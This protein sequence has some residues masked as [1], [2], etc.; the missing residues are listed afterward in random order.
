MKRFFCSLCCFLLAL[1]LNAQADRA[2]RIPGELIVSLVDGV[3]T[4]QWFKEHVVNRSFAPSLVLVRDLGIRHSFMLLRFEEGEIPAEKALQQVQ[5]LPNVRAVQY[6]YNVVFRN[7]PNDNQYFRQWSMSVID[8]PLAWGHST[9]GTTENG[10]PIVVAVMDS[11]FELTHEDLEPNLWHNAAETPGD[12]IDNDNNGYIDDV[13]GWDY[14][15]DSPNIAP[16]NHGLSTASIVGAKGNNGVGV[17]GVNW[18]V[19]LMLFSFSSVADLISAYEYVI[20]QR[21]R[22]NESNGAAGAFVVATNNSFGQERIWCDQQAVW[23]SMYD[24]MGEVGILSSAGVGNSR[25]DADNVGDMPAS[26]TSDYL[27]ISCN[28]DEDDNLYNN[29]AYGAISV[30][31]GAPG[32][33][34][35]TAKPGNSY[36]IFGG[37]SAATPHVTGAIALLYSGPCSGV[38]SIAINQPAETALFIKNFL[39]NSGDLTPSLEN[40]TLT[41]RRLNVGTA[42]EQL[43]ASCSNQLAPLQLSKVFPNPVKGLLTIDYSAPM[44]GTY[45]AEIY[46]ALGQLASYK[47]VIVGEVG[48]RTF[49]I[50]TSNLAAGGYFLR[51][52]QGD[53]WVMQRVVVM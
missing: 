34:S 38:E 51:F 17:T 53:E 24:L 50:E 13:L 22:F 29:S 26:C 23:G 18:D 11:G 42:M 12:G 15:S 52:G 48:V 43:I 14:F 28:T 47:E 46:N 6:N 9:G 20:D 19:E 16:G 44:N 49:T 45:R 41:G 1:S 10:T 5:Q 39:M 32:E 25:Y 40:R 2:D 7:E 4:E 36:G 3:N 27:L 8:A 31:I 35:Y 21:Q 33:G 37:N 30:D